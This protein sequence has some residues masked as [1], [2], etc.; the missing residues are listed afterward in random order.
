MAKTGCTS[1]EARQAM[2]Q[3]C[4]AFPQCPKCGC[5]EFFTSEIKTEGLPLKT[6]LECKKCG[7]FQTKYQEEK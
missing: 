5:S 6:W 1:G 2:K 4:P 3:I 7:K